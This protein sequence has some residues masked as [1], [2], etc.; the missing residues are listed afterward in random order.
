VMRTTHAAA[1]VH[2]TLRRPS[3]ANSPELI[4]TVDVTLDTWMA[5]A[6]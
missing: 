6:A 4:K 5:P 3:T 2:V 1:T